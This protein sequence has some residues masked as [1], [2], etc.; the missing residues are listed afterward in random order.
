L[1]CNCIDPD[2]VL[3]RTIDPSFMKGDELPK[4]T[5][6]ED[7]I[8]TVIDKLPIPQIDVE[9]VPDTLTVLQFIYEM[10]AYE[11]N[12]DQVIRAILAK[13][14][15]GTTGKNWCSATGYNY[16]RTMNMLVNWMIKRQEWIKTK[17]DL[18]LGKP[19]S[20]NLL[21]H[22]H[23][24]RLIGMYMGL[25]AESDE[26]KTMFIE[27]VKGIPMDRT[28]RADG[29]LKPLKEIMQDALDEKVRFEAWAK[30][31]LRVEAEEKEDTVAFAQKKTKREKRRQLRRRRR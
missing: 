28:R 12:Q 4:I 16:Q 7:Q 21:N 26:T 13:A 24:F 14:F 1:I 29:S 31:Q 3:K 30:T 6:K 27:S 8:W 22:I 17:G 9:A 20:T 23:F 18:E 10:K 5:V 19:I 11:G 15:Q 2:T 25:K